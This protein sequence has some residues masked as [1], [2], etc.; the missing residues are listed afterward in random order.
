MTRPYFPVETCKNL[1]ILAL[2]ASNV[3]VRE[4][5]IKSLAEGI[6]RAVDDWFGD[7]KH[8]APKHRPSWN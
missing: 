6:K 4:E 5:D 8:L 2:T 3:Q 1:A 7:M